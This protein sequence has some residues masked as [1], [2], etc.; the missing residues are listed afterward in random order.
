MKLLVWIGN[1]VTNCEKF[2]TKDGYMNLNNMRKTITVRTCLVFR[3]FEMRLR[4]I[5]R[6]FLD[7]LLV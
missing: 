7:N 4:P 2:G 3:D 5:E 1:L 6:E